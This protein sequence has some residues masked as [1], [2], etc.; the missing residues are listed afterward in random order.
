MNRVDFMQQLESLLQSI[1]PMERDEALQYYN[2]YFDDAGKENEQEVIGALGN[3]ARV[4][5]NIRRDL[6][7]S[8]YGEGTMRKALASDRALVEY[9]KETQDGTSEQSDDETKRNISESSVDAAAGNVGFG[10]GENAA[11]QGAFGSAMAGGEAFGNPTTESGTSGNTAAGN[12]SFG[13]VATQSNHAGS[14]T[15]GSQQVWATSQ[16]DQGK[17]GKTGKSGMPGWEIALIV[18]LVVFTSPVWLGLIGAALGVVGALLGVIAAWFAVI[19][20]FGVVAVCMLVVVIV[21]VVVGF[22]CMFTNPWVGLA[23]IGSGLVCGGIGILF[24]MATV[25]MAGIVTPAMFR[26]IGS[27]FRCLTKKSERSLQRG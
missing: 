1:A 13:N 15:Y 3:P 12:G 18:A 7:N 21:L 14:E 4:A 22:M 5:E 16:Q 17:A 10:N 25:A 6:L 24:L 11:A 26:G 2:D 8:G 20:A 9:G 27:L 23:M 19:V